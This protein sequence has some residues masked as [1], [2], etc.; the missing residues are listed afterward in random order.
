MAKEKIINILKQGAV[1]WNAW[2]HE[3]HHVSQDLSVCL[4]LSGTDLRDADL[5]RT[6]L[7]R[8]DL[9][10]AYLNWADLRSADLRDAN[11]S[12]ATLYNANLDRTNLSRADLRNA[13]LRDANL[14]YA[15]LNSADLRNANLCNADLSYADLRNAN[16]SGASV[17][18]TVF[19]DNDLSETLGLESL[20]HI[21]PSTIGIDTLYKSKGKIPDAFLRKAGVPE[22]LITYLPSLMGKAVGYYACFISFTEKDDLF[23]ERLYNDLLAKGVRCWRWKEDAKW[24]KTLMKSIDEAVGAYDKL[25]VIC[26]EQSLQSPAVIREIER[27]LQ[28]EDELARQGKDDEVLFPVRLD[29]YI[30]SN[31]QHYRK[32]D[33]TSK[34]IGDF[35]NWNDPDSYSKCLNR[36]L[37]DL[38]PE[39]SKA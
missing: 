4:D 13:D 24:G 17:G 5:S 19:G 12:R 30:F 18:I 33:V 27:A 8:A 3:N 1:K 9:H 39:S 25:V 10:N 21:Y 35:R 31:W 34:N 36:L 22:D 7:R 2:V 11:L 16:L 28:K 15:Y 29:D 38:K 23:S 32:A 6:F 20:N 26:S 14:S 37:R